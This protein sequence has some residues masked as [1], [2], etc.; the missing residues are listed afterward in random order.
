A[1]L[2]EAQW[3]ISEGGGQQMA[4][5]FRCTQRVQGIVSDIDRDNGT[6][7]IE[8]QELSG[9]PQQLAQVMPGQSVSV[10]VAEVENRPWIAELQTSGATAQAGQ[11][12]QPSGQQQGGQQQQEQ[13]PVQG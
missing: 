2:V 12:Q 7:T 5:M 4:Q 3:V 10:Q 9:H 11:Q 8:G 1:R 13:Q 6:I